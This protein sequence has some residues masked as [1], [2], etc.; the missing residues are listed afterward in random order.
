MRTARDHGIP[1][2][3]AHGCQSAPVIGPGRRCRARLLPGR[4]GEPGT[5]GTCGELRGPGCR[6]ALT[7][8]RRSRRAHG[9]ISAAGIGWP[10]TGVAGMAWAGQ[11]L[12]TNATTALAAVCR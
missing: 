6:R 2:T 10:T 1:D 8:S 4:F 11:P 3:C 5:A 7:D 9:A 12:V